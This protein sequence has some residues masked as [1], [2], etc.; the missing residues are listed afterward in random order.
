MRHRVAE[1]EGVLLDAAVAT[2]EGL[3]YSRQQHWNR[4]A[5]TLRDGT[6]F[7]PSTDPAQGSPIIEREFGDK[8]ELP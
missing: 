2:A 3:E 6:E 4:D 7:A 8:V 5:V 1:L